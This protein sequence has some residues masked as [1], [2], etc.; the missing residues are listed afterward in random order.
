MWA[1]AHMIDKVGCE[2]VHVRCESTDVD[3]VLANYTDGSYD[4]S[5]AHNC[6]MQ[7]CPQRIGMQFEM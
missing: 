6:L 7:L 5:H 2:N 3:Y 1:F 4:L